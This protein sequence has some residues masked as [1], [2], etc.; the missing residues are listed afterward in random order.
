MNLREEETFDPYIERISLVGMLRLLGDWL[1]TQAQF[2]YE[3]V[4]GDGYIY[5]MLSQ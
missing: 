1:D 3:L 2:Y 4:F 5:W